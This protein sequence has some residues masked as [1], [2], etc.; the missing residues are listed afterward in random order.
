[1]SDMT[2]LMITG[3]AGLEP[4]AWQGDFTGKKQ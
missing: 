1:M 4:D 2:R 3:I